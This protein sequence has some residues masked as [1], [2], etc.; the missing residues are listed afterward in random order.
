MTAVRREIRRSRTRC[1][2]AHLQRLGYEVLGGLLKRNARYI[3]DELKQDEIPAVRVA[4]SRSR[5]S[6]DDDRLVQGGS[7]SSET[8]NVCWNGLG[9]P[10]CRFS[11]GKLIA[12]LWLSN[13]RVVIELDESDSC[14]LLRS[15]RTGASRSRMPFVDQTQHGKRCHDLTH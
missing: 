9:G 1:A 3:R 6:V 2:P 14:H 8:I 15:G 5:N 4:E 12:A 13:S 11:S 7:A 10:Q